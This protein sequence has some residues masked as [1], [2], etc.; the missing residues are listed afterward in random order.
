MNDDVHSA[1]LAQ[2]LKKKIRSHP[3]YSYKLRLLANCMT[4]ADAKQGVQIISNGRDSRI[5]GPRAC[6]HSWACPECTARIMRKYSTRIAA[7]IDALSKKGYAATM[8]T[9]TVFHS[10]MM[11]CEDTFLLLNKAWNIFNKNKTWSKKRKEPIKKTQK[12]NVKGNTYKSCGAWSRFYQEFGCNHTVKTLETTYG[13]HGWHP[14]IHMLIWVKNEDLQK[15]ADWEEELNKDWAVAV[16]KAAKIIYKENEHAYEVRKF[17]ESKTDRE[18]SEHLGLFISK[19]TDGKIKRWS[20]GDYLCGWGGENE[21][22]GLGMKTAR[23]DNMTPFQML[24]KAHDLETTDITQSNK[25]IELYLTFAYTV[26]KYRISRIQ[27]SRTGLKAIINTHLQTEE[28]KA[29]IKKKKES[30]HIAPYRNIAWF[31]KKQWSDICCSDNPYL[32]PLILHFAKIPEDPI[33]GTDGYYWICELCIANN[34]DPPCWT[35]HPTMD[36]AKSFNELIAA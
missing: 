15:L 33:Y 13:N 9:F 6:Q 7:A 4:Y 35:K 19:T 2:W 32:I 24:E 36:L 31:T 27:F 18:D 23:K 14:H 21:L 28:F 12:N 34:L 17:L 16:D 22:T 8:F 5:I 29:V 26:I 25:L 30:L 20:S 11:S 10:T 1:M 3:Y